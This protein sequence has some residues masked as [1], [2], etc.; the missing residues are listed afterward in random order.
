MLKLSVVVPTWNRR[1]LL[2][3]T[4]PALLQQTMSPESYEVIVIDDGSTDSTW[5]WLQALTATFPQLR[6]HRLVKNQGRVCARNVGIDKAL[7]DIVLFIDS[8]VLPSPGL[9]AAHL[10]THQHHPGPIIV[11]GPLILIHVWEPL[12]QPRLWTDYSRAFFAT[13][14]VS[15]ARRAFLQVGYFDEGF[16][17]YGWEDLELGVRLKQHGY[18]LIHAPTALA[19][20]YEPWPT[21]AHLPDL[22]AK[23]HARRQGARY[24]YAKHPTWEVRLMAQM[25]FAHR[26]LAWLLA[27]DGHWQVDAWLTLANQLRQKGYGS[28]GLAL[29]RGYLNSR[30]HSRFD[31]PNHQ[32]YGNMP[33]DNQLDI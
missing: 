32:K 17:N 3:R 28:L 31:E 33:D 2:Q 21:S 4:L 6:P 16:T 18:R 5:E 24:F 11:Q 22:L 27:G 7:A 12:P 19:W 30:D 23:E 20:H 1:P 8:D 13:G 26:G 25:T 10:A 29:W 15:V 9:L 14:Q